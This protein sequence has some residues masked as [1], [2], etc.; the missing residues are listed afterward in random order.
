MSRAE[1][2]WWEELGDSALDGDIKA[3][4][5]HNP[6]LRAVSLRIDRAEAAASH[7][8]AAMLPSL[9]LGFGYREGRARDVDFGPYSLAP[10]ETSTGLSWEVDA[11]GKL[12]A[13]RRA[14]QAGTEVA[15][16]NYQS[17]RL[18]LSS[19]IAAT[20]LNLYRFNAELALLEESLAANRATLD[21]LVERSEA[22][23]I[24]RSALAKQGAENEKLNRLQL[25]L[26]RLRDLTIVQLRTLRGGTLPGKTAR[27]IFP[28]GQGERDR[29]KP[30]DQILALHPGILAAGAEVRAAFE[31]EQAAKLDLLPSFK[32]EALASGATFSLSDRFRTWIAKVG[33][34]LDIPI[35][36]PSRLAVVRSRQAQRQSAAAGYRSE[37]LRVLQEIDSARINLRSRHKQ[38][39][40]AQREVAE[41]KTTRDFAREQF[42]AGITSQIEYLDAERRWLEAKRSA[43]SLEQAALNARID[44]TRAAGG[45]LF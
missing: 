30:L 37:V 4:F 38:L 23:L 16:W 25:D 42:D 6:D 45:G 29:A 34:S 27:S 28:R 22:G 9:N 1:I 44:L 11:S 10:W 36:D 33:P 5:T 26:T 15:I 13:A 41:I 43:I 14:A 7:A 24:A 35:Y 40:A 18:L 39:A 20:R 19:R 2:R 21:T 32:I 17:A 3:A 12:R 8:R 31:I